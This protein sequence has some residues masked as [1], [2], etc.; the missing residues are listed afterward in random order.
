M[1]ER[2]AEGWRWD[3]GW[4][5]GM[6]M[7]PPPSPPN[8]GVSGGGGCWGLGGTPK[9]GGVGGTPKMGGEGGEM[10]E[11]GLR[12]G[13]GLEVGWRER[14]QMEPPPFPKSGCLWWGGGVLGFGGTPKMGGVF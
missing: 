9:T 8:M 3:G 2:G 11:M 1:G 12:I 5:E 14:K 6:Q 10:G 7:E 4:R 13:G